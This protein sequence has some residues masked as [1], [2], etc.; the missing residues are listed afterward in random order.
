MKAK[1][2]MFTETVRTPLG[3][4]RLAATTQGLAGVWFIGQKHE[5]DHSAWLPQP[6]QPHLRLAAT[7]LSAYFS[8][9]RTTF[10]LPLDWTLGTPFQQSV[11]HALQQIPPGSTWTYQA[12]ANHLGRPQAVRAVGAAIGRNPMSIVVP[13]HRVVGSKGSLTGYAGGLDRKAALLQL[14]SALIRQSHQSHPQTTSARYQTASE[15]SAH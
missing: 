15:M 11:W 7:Q 6:E 14:E 1:S 9:T 5:P 4:L 2:P 3:T 8:Q 10:D 13:C 12:L